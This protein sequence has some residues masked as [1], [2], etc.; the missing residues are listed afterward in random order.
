MFDLDA[1]NGVVVSDND[2]DSDSSSSRSD[3]EVSK[4]MLT[5]AQV[6]IL[7]YLPIAMYYYHHSSQSHS[8]THSEI[9]FL[10][11]Y[12]IIYHHIYT[13]YMIFICL[14]NLYR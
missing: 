10:I 14:D 2:G 7:F 6:R 9:I 3:D 13:S 12:L 5:A 8:L 1:S 11:A 4:R